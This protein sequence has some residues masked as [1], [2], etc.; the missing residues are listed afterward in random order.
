MPMNSSTSLEAV[1]GCPLAS[2]LLPVLRLGFEKSSTEC[3]IFIYCKWH[4][5][6][7]SEREREIAPAN[8]LVKGL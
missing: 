2:L 7:E 8:V 5:E 3:Q 6:R 1:G 4:F